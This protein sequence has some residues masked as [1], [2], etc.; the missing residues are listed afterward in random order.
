MHWL[1]PRNQIVLFYFSNA[2]TIEFFQEDD[3]IPMPSPTLLEV[4][5]RISRILNVTGVAK[6][7]DTL[8]H[9]SQFDCHVAS[10]GSTDLAAAIGR[11]LL[12]LA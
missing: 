3:S 6:E 10:D 11:R 1:R 4:H 5:E 9:L 8:I 2:T 12:I 7:L